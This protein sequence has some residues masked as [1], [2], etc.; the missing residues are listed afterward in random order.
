MSV[1]LPA[2][3]P[4]HEF[5]VPHIPSGVP[6]CITISCIHCIT[7]MSF[8]SQLF[9]ETGT[10]SMLVTIQPDNARG[11]SLLELEQDNESSFSSCTFK[12]RWE[13]SNHKP[14]H[15]KQ[16]QHHRS[17]RSCTSCPPSPPMRRRGDFESDE[18]PHSHS[19]SQSR[20]DHISPESD[21]PAHSHSN[22]PGSVDQR[23]WDEKSS[24]RHTAPAIPRRRVSVKPPKSSCE[25]L[26]ALS[27]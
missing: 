14:C 15:S 23:R 10:S 25:I 6:H 24:I 8:F 27:A 19:H 22:C 21:D 4:T 11:R 9:A 2:F 3:Q 13:G 16:H 1:P 18:K 12:S 17:P 20:D 5:I 7:T 26:A